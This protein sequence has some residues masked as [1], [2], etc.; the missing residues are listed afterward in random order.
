MRVEGHLRRVLARLEKERS[1]LD[2]RITLFKQ[3]LAELEA[4][5]QKPML[6]SEP[7]PRAEA[8]IPSSVPIGGEIEYLQRRDD[9]TN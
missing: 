7:G 4:A 6:A 5:D 3:T 8:G 2:E 1:D 9:D